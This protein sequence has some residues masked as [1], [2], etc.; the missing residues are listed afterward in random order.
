MKTTVVNIKTHNYDEYIGRPSPLGNR[1][2]IGVDGTREE[3]IER[4]SR[5]FNASERLKKIARDTCIDKVIGCYC[6]PFA[7]HGDIIAEYLN[8]LK[9]DEK[10][11][12]SS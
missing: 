11:T 3:C 10:R 7:C 8:G 4:Y 5:D 2:R 9:K 12:A 1:Y 6:K